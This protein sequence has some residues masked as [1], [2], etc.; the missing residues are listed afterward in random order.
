MKES[1]LTVEL[2][3]FNLE[4]NLNP[5]ILR[6]DPFAR[7]EQ[8]LLAAIRRIN[9]HAAPLG[10]ELVP[11]GILPTLRQSDIGAEVMTDE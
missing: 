11:I 9:Q 7:T 8:E 6:G 3:R 4:Y 10:G 5:Q 1:Q 2:N